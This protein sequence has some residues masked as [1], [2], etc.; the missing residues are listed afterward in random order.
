MSR[1][2]SLDLARGFTVFVMPA[3]HVVML[4]SHAP[5]QQSFLGTVLAF[6]AEGPGAQLFM[7]LMGISMTLSSRLNAEFVLKRSIALL[8]AGYALNFLKF[9]IP[10]GL[11]IFPVSLLQEL[12]LQNNDSA[13]V[14]LLSIG[15]ILHFAAIAYLFIYFV[16]RLP[17]YYYWALVFALLVIFL[18]PVFWDLHSNSYIVNYFFQLMGGH[19]PQ[20][21]FPVFPWIVYPLI[22]LHIGYYLKCLTVARVFNNMGITGMM[23]L[24]MGMM[25]PESNT[26]VAWL[27]FY[28][29]HASATLYHLGVVLL[30]L[31]LCQ[32]I[33]QNVKHQLFF[34]LLSFLSKNITLVYVIQWILIAWILPFVGYH[35]LGFIPTIF[36]M[37]TITGVSLFLSHLITYI[38]AT[39]KN[40]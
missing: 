11:G 38:Y 36:F 1:I 26:I 12:H 23:L 30:W 8:L 18:S 4:Y 17:R 2:Q 28:R 20:V 33:I 31:Y 10:L 32:W 9:I 6:L 25:L 21:F 22:G 37:T 16:Y 3:I 34:S 24:L 35:T 7:L 14:P 40:I 29:T 15:D 39:K 5:V 27:P 13:I 19:P